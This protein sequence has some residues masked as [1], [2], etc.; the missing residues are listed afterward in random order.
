MCASGTGHA[1][2]VPFSPVNVAIHRHQFTV[3]SCLAASARIQL[4]NRHKIVQNSRAHEV[5][6]VSEFSTF[7]ITHSASTPE[8][9]LASSL[10]HISAVH[11]VS[12]GSVGV[13]RFG[14]RI[15]DQTK[16]PGFHYVLPV[17]SQLT[18][19][20]VNVRTCVAW[21]SRVDVVRDARFYCVLS[22]I[23]GYVP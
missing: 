22:S 19:V 16:A 7:F 8:R 13:L 1:V 14:G 12:E 18:E 3:P 23:H 20:P 2:I 6:L 5:S 21:H 17:I 15:L 4:W 9:L 10:L 11:V